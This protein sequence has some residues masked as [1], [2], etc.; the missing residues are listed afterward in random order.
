MKVSD[1]IYQSRILLGDGELPYAWEDEEFAIYT[2]E[3]YKEM[4]RLTRCIQ[5]RPTGA[6]GDICT[7]SITASTAEYSLS[8]KIL[9]VYSVKHSALSA[10]LGKVTEAELDMYYPNWWNITDSYP[11]YYLLNRALNKITLIP[12]PTATG[13]N[14]LKLTVS[15]LPLISLLPYEVEVR[16]FEPVDLREEWQDF[17]L[18][19][20]LYKAYSKNDIETRND[21]K[22]GENLAIWIDKIDQVKREIAR[23]R[24]V[25]R[26]FA[27]QNGCI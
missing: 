5:D 8:K 26:P 3:A 9:D 12:I 16:N 7:I 25:D 10:P 1:Y 6:V 2:E 24:R 15:R 22:A 20:I 19:Y 13:T 4:T 14:T 27:P 18:Y 23:Y 17:L 11:K 21:K